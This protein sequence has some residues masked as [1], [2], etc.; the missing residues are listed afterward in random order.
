MIQ[1]DL[2]WLKLHRNYLYVSIKVGVGD[3]QKI[4][5]IYN[6][7]TGQKKAPNGCGSCMRNT[8]KL[9]KQHYEKAT[10]TNG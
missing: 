1:S 7:L 3:A 4:Y 10:K 9:I 8:I 6:R 2:E 5:D